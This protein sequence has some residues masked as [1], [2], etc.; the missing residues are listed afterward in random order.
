MRQLIEKQV[1]ST[2]LA[3]G[4]SPVKRIFVDGGFSK[5]E[6]YMQLLAVAFPEMEVYAAEVA[7]ATALGA[8]LAVHHTWNAE[9]IPEN[10]ILLKKYNH[11]SV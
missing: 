9:P 1:V 3:I 6:I 7:Q 8:A 2:K 11:T 5:N 4:N 10:L